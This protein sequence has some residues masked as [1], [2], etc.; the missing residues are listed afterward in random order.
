MLFSSD[1]L[2]RM[3]N[4]TCTNCA[5]GTGTRPAV[6]GGLLLSQLPAGVV[7]SCSHRQHV[8][9]PHWHHVGGAVPLYFLAQG[10]LW[11]LFTH[12]WPL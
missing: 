2:P 11:H 5:N 1:Y 6:T 12:F 3:R 4:C 10:Q 9:Q 8:E 7:A